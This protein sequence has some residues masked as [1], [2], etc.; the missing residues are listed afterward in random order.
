[1]TGIRSQEYDEVVDKLV[2]DQIVIDMAED[3]IRL[4][5][6]DK[7]T[8]EELNSWEKM[9][10]ANQEYDRAGGLIK[11]RHIGAVH[12]AICEIVSHVLVLVRVLARATNDG[13]AAASWWVEVAWTPEH[14][15]DLLRK[16]NDGD[17]EVLDELP[18]PR[19][20]GE[21]ADEPMWIDVL[22]DVDALDADMKPT[23]DLEQE[24]LDNQL[25]D[26]YVE[27]FNIA[28]NDAITTELAA[29]AG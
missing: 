21:F 10:L 19:L 9:Q 6:A 17:P 12:E 26:A 27:A 4:I 14:C 11:S 7:T 8:F 23:M 24:Y 3:V 2:K 13:E 25:Y 28:A 15:A 1:V 16:I 22:R 20:G 5:E 18:S 29:R